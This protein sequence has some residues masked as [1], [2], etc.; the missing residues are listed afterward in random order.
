MKKLSLP[1]AVLVGLA[2]LEGGCST[3]TRGDDPSPV[4]LTCS[5]TLLPA[6]KCVNS[7]TLLQFDTVSV[8]SHLKNPT[9]TSS[10]FLDT[11]VE[12]YTIVWNRVD[13]GKTA[14]KTETF[15]G[16]M[17]VPVGGNST[18]TNYPFMSI[19]ALTQP[20]LSFLWPSNGG[21]DPETGRTEIRQTGTVTFNGHTM[22]GQ[23]VTSVPAPF[24][25]TFV[26]CP[27]TGR[28]APVSGR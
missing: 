7:G 10:S 25:M 15:G 9:G 11:Q 27:A 20:P 22:S 23:P 19:S 3:N 12:T 26:Y 6:T 13:G 17:I 4:Y 18:L 16:N 21:V 24:D 1:L 2:L 28:I 8:Q 14:S 5:F